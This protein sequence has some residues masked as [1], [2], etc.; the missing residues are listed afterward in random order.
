MRVP[1]F[2]T[3]LMFAILAT[4][5]AS[6][7]QSPTVQRPAGPDGAPSGPV[8]S[9]DQVVGLFSAS[10]L[11]FAGDVA[12]MRSFLTEQHA[13][14]MPQ[15][16]RDAFLAGRQGQVFDVSFQTA[17]LALVSLDD[18]GCEAVAEHADPGKVVS[19]LNQAA[20]ENHVALQP[21]G[22]PADAKA[23][24]G[25][26]QTAFGLTLAGHPMHI[27]VSTEAQAPQAVL[28]LIPK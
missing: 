20:Q 25:V 11:N 26:Q 4:S 21:L 9:A 23:R 2:A 5:G 1:A 24:P 10:C 18:G 13:P 6:R 17:K 7:A 14:Q 12:A 16:A 22:T 8:D 15:A 27:L 19:V 3:A 28:T